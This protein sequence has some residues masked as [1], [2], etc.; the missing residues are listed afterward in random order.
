MLESLLF[1]LITTSDK[2]TALLAVPEIC[3]DNIITLYN[4]SLF[5]GHQGVVKTYLTINDRFFYPRSCALSEII[6]KG[7]S[8]LS[9]C[10]NR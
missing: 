10:Q 4:T 1:K 6:Q 9:N 7:M 5:A 3:M 2:E 8:Y